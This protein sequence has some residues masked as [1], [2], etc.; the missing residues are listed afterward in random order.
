M[1]L[2]VLKLQPSSI[3]RRLFSVIEFVVIGVTTPETA[4]KTHPK[5]IEGVTFANPITEVNKVIDEV[6]APR[7][8]ADN[9][10]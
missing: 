9:R 6:E 3:K 4:I 7:A 1:A 10:V 2:V 5:N 8:L